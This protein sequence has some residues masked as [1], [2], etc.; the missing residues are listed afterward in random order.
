MWMPVLAAVIWSLVSTSAGP[1][2]ID[3]EIPVLAGSITLLLSAVTVAP[4]PPVALLITRMPAMPPL[5][6]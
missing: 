3:I 4:P 5:L 1:E 6:T 2:T